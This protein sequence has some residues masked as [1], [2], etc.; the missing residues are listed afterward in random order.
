M[1]EGGFAQPGPG[2][3][4]D[5]AHTPRSATTAARTG[6]SRRPPSAATATLADHPRRTL[7][8]VAAL[9]VS[10]PLLAA[11]ASST[12]AAPGTPAAP[13]PS[14]TPPEALCTRI[15]THWAR[16][17]LVGEG[18]GDYQS[19]GLS[20]GQY[21][22]LRDVLDAARAERERQGARAADELIEHRAR[23][24]CVAWYRSGGPGEGPWR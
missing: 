1:A 13:S 6:R 17:L 5:P 9:V 23:T 15:V 22:I 11:C 18:Y 8:A 12:P 21:T 2:H 7:L 16:E 14:V 10:L 20:D 4:G 19:M 24:G 3:R